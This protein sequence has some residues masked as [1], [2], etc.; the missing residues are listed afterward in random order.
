MARVPEPVSGAVAFAK[1][2]ALARAA[3][4]TRFART[5][6]RLRVAYAMAMAVFN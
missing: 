5:E 1:V 2:D 4:I 3:I 6:A